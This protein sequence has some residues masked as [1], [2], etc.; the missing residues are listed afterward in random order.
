MLSRIARRLRTGDDAGSA[1]VVVLVV[2][3]VLTIGG[4]AVATVVTSTTGMLVGA[5]GTTQSRAAADAGMSVAVAQARTAAD[6]CSMSVPTSVAAPAYAVTVACDLT[7]KTV[8][9]TST[10][11]AAGRTSTT[12]SVYAMLPPAPPTYGNIAFRTGS[13]TVSGSAYD[14]DVVLRQGALTCSG[15]TGSKGGLYT[16]SGNLTMSGCAVAGDVWVTGNLVCSGSTIGGNL[17]VTGTK[18]LSG[19]TVKGSILSAP[20]A[21]PTMAQLLASSQWFDLNSATTW[22]STYVKAT[23]YSG[24]TCNTAPANIISQAGQT[25]AAPVVLDATACSS[26]VFS[27]SSL[28]VLRDTVLLYNSGLTMSGVSIA[29][30]SGAAHQLLLVQSN[31][32]T[33]PLSLGPNCAGRSGPTM[34]GVGVTP[35]N[36]KVLFYT[37]CGV[38]GS[39][40][41][42]P[43]QIISGASVASG[44]T[45]TCQSMTVPGVF[46]L[47]C[48]L[49]DGVTAGGGTGGIALGNLVARR[50]A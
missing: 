50:D 21:A 15:G 24:G 32:S 8:T 14:G 10:G 27:G 30:S 43:G 48:Y 20:P 31:T 34:S 28:N 42:F 33:N 26:L 9:F 44:A 45:Q 49:K 36:L 12:V 23:P 4:L 41:S 3:L 17:Y 13:Y 18:T 39:G 22:P 19:C 16:L 6:V 35:T 29:N 40:T 47:G 37:P 7:A 1:I 46:G 5:R 2:M 38:V 11:T 25:G